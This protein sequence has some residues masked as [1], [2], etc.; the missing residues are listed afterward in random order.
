MENPLK[1]KQKKQPRLKQK[2]KNRIKQYGI[3]VTLIL[4]F[5]VLILLFPKAAHIIRA[6]SIFLLLCEASLYDIVK[7]E[8]PVHTCVG[9]AIVNIIYSVCNTWEF[10]LWISGILVVVVLSLL[11]FINRGGIGIGDILLLGISIPAVP[12]KNIVIFLFITFFLSAMTGII[13]SIRKKKLTGTVIPLVPCIT[14]S[15]VIANLI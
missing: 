12:I 11:F 3:A 10:R 13:K 14:A 6:V 9:A 8:I 2:D 5:T 15:F 4:I 1:L 7:N